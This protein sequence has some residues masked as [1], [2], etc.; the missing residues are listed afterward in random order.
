[1]R[2]TATLFFV[3]HALADFDLPELKAEFERWGHNPRHAG[4]L[5]R[6]FYRH[7]G[8]IDFAR[9]KIGRA[10]RERLPSELLLRRAEVAARVESADGT[11]KFLLRLN[12]KDGDAVETVL[13]PTP[14]GD[15]A[16][17]CVSSQIGCALACDFCASTRGGFQ[18]NLDSGEIVEQFLFLRAEAARTGR[19]LRTLVFMGMGEPL[20]NLDHVVRAIRR[21]AGEELGALGWR[22]VTVS[23]AGVAPEMDRLAEANLG[24]PLALSL[25]APDDETRSRLVP[26][27][28][29]YPV[30]AVLAALKRFAARS[31]RIPTVEY[32]L[33][34]GV[35]DSDAQARQLAALLEGFRAHVNLIPYNQV[36]R[37]LSGAEYAPP[38]LER[39]KAFLNVLRAAGTVAHLRLPRGADVSAACGQLRETATATADERR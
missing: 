37:G 4:P 9:L 6:A 24:I 39:C 15:C 8:E 38:P 14:R 33:L 31:G 34:A 30:A 5:L 22:Q 11:V 25:H 29:K 36:G 12:G 23:T 16:A 10:L 20:L 7:G 13:M 1:L 19:R 21:I 17:G 2:E 18:R 35:N 27:N 32:C 3:K 26:L 28:R